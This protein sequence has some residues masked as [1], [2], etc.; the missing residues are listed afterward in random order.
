MGQRFI[1][2]ANRAFVAIEANIRLEGERV[3]VTLSVHEVCSFFALFVCRGLPVQQLASMNSVKW[4]YQTSPK[5]A[6]TILIEV[7]LAPLA[8][9]VKLPPEAVGCR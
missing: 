6:F 7:P 1:T 8:V 9:I 4:A 3:R 5:V 2:R